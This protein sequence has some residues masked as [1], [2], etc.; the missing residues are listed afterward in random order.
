MTLLSI[1]LPRVNSQ[2]SITSTM[3]S[4]IVILST[5]ALSALGDNSTSYQLPAGFNIGLVKP[6]ELSMLCIAHTWGQR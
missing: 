2:A 1:C 6:D 4:S 5:L 3:L